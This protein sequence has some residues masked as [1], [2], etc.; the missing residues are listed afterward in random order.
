LENIGDA[1]CV[2]GSR[3]IDGALVS[4]R[5]PLLRRLAS[6]VLNKIVVHG[7]FGLDIRDSQCG[8]KLFHRNVIDS[9][10]PEATEQ[11]WAFDID[12]L[13]R[14]KRLGYGIREFP[15]EWHHVPGNSTTFMLM[16]LQMI[17]SVWR[18]K[19]ALAR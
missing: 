11:G 7:I 5:Q 3:W 12:L 9:V 19:R 8:A 15:I 17:A 14:A 13:C 6:R 2:I 18:V 16:S 10:L 4:P 1:G